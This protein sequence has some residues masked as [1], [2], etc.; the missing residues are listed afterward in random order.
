MFSLFN[1]IGAA[2]VGREMEEGRGQR[3]E[4]PQTM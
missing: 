4:I 2:V 3:G 1:K